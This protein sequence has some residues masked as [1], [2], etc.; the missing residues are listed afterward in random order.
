MPTK[1]IQKNIVIKNL[2]GA[3]RLL[4]ALE[5]AEKRP[6]GPIITENVAEASEDDIRKGWCK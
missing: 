3:W 5:E 6:T 1:S 2:R 4:R